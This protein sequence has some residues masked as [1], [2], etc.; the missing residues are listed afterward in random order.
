M[1]KRIFEAQLQAPQQWGGP[2]TAD[3]KSSRFA[4][5]SYDHREVERWAKCEHDG[6]SIHEQQTQ[7]AAQLTAAVGSFFQ[8]RAAATLCLSAKRSP[9]PRRASGSYV[10]S[11]PRVPD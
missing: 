3:G 5:L 1:I 11:N 6:H 8:Q 7:A 9:R 10:P 2:A 4:G